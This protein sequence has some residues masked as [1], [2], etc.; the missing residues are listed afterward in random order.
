M[1]VGQPK[2]DDSIEIQLNALL[3]SLDENPKVCVEP[4]S[5]HHTCRNSQNGTQI[6]RE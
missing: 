4:V 2:Y 6:H 5:Y 3:C 1:T